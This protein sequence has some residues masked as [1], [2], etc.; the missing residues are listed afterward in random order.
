MLLRGLSPA[1][2]TQLH[3]FVATPPISATGVQ[4]VIGLCAG[5]L[6]EIAFST[7]GG[8]RCGLVRLFRS[9]P[10]SKKA[11]C[12][13]QCPVTS[14]RRSLRINYGVLRTLW[15]NPR[16][17]AFLLGLSARSARRPPSVTTRQ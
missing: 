9:P 13:L 4:R 7:G 14:P 1:F 6:M 3:R 8:R 5:F 11:H 12:F 16:G 10:A 2:E 17:A 15:C